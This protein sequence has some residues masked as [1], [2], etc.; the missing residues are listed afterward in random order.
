MDKTHVPFDQDI[1][2]FGSYQYTGDSRLSARLANQRYTEMILACA[3]FRD[4]SVVDVGCGDGTYAADLARLSGAA[5]ILGIDPAC[6]AIEYA[7]ARY[8]DLAP[9]VQFVCGTASD[10]LA[11]ARTFD[12]AVYR[13]VIHHTADPLSEIRTAMRLARTVIIL[14]PNGQNPLMKLLELLSPYHRSHGERSFSQ[15]VMCRWIRESNG[16]VDLFR[17]FGLVPFFC[18]DVMARLGRWLEPLLETIP[19]LPRFYCGQYVLA[20]TGGVG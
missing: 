8:D 4:K 2:L 3:D 14:E 17:F 6:K 7:S 18:P 16:R 1:D 20:A 15:N 9:R 11:Q 13:G 10:L 5:K 12:I 19:V